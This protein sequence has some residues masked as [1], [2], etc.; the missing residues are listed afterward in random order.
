MK[1]VLIFILFLATNAFAAKAYIDNIEDDDQ[2]ISVFETPGQ[3]WRYCPKAKASDCKSAVGWLD[4]DSEIEIIEDAKLFDTKDPLTEEFQKDAFTKVKFTYW[5]IWPSGNKV[6]K[7]GEGYIPSTY[8][9]KKKTAAFFSV[10]QNANTVKKEICPPKNVFTEIKKAITPLVKPI[11][12]LSVAEK[13]DALKDVVG[14]CPFKPPNK[15][16]LPPLNTKKEN[17]YETLIKSKLEENYSGKNTPKILNEDNKPMTTDNLIEID[18]L[19]RT[20]Y[21]EMAICYRK[22][23]QYPMTVAR[24]IMNRAENKSRRSEFTDPPHEESTPDIVKV[25]TTPSQFNVWYKQIEGSKNNTLHHGLCPPQHEDKPYWNGKKA[26]KYEAD[27][28]KNSVRIATEAILY[29]TKFKK[30]TTDVDGYHYTSGMGKFYKMKQDRSVTIEGHAV[31]NS[32][33]LEIWKE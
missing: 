1:F 10:T 5:A 20:L 31:D 26:S 21:G 13:A 11:E 6:L 32:A 30:R 22:G 24:I 4:R 3:T 29:P 27:I 14:F 18:A 25:C 33:C 12:N 8:I 17:V 2:K 16:L 28:W 7:T 15:Y 23:L 19:A 9:S